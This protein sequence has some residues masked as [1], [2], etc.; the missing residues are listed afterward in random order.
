MPVVRIG[1][2]ASPLAQAQSRQMHE[3]MAQAAAQAGLEYN[4]DRAVPINT[5]LGHQ[6]L[7]F[8]A[9]HGRQNELKERLFRAYYTEGQNLAD[10]DTLARLAAETGLDATA[11][12]EAL[13]A[14]TYAEAVRHDEY[15]ARQVGVRG[16]PFFVFADKY[17]VSGAPPAEVFAEVLQTVWREANPLVAVGSADGAVCGPEGC[18]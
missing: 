5:F 2:R 13:L 4:F 18:D 14:G 16:V 1:T 12:R 8:A 3:Q 17:A 11:A 15:Q 6:L 9:A 10:L 7:H